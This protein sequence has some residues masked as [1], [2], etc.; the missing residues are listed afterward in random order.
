MD[1][2]ITV[3]QKKY[4]L[5]LSEIYPSVQS[6]CTEIISI[7]ANLNLPKG[8]EHFMSDLH[9]E[10]E[11]FFH[12]LNNC[13]G[14]IKEKV[15]ACFKGRLS[16][17]EC[18]N[19]CTLIYY[20]RERLEMLLKAGAVNACWY[21][22]TLYS[23]IELTSRISSKYTRSKVRSAVPAEYSFIIDELLH[24]QPDEDD[25]QYIYHQR[26]IETVFE[27][28]IGADFIADMA[29]LIKRLA[30][31]RLHIVGDI[32]DRGA[33][34][35]S[36]MDMLSSHHCVDI[37][38][39]NHDILWMGAACGSDVCICGVIR[40]C[41]TYNNTEV[42]E[43]GYGIPLR[44]L[45]L[46]SE[47]LYPELTPLEAA[48]KVIT[49]MMF[50]LEGQLISRHSEYKMDDKMLLHKIDFISRTIE[51]GDK[52]YDVSGDFPTI[53]EYAPYALTIEEER[54]L[55]ELRKAFSES[56][57]L[58][59]HMKFL[60]DNG[61]LYRCHNGNLL[62]HGCI[63][64]NEN[65]SF[66]SM[67]FGGKNYSG[68]EYFD[69]ADKCVRKAY[70]END[71]NLKDFMWFLWSAENS[72]LSGR[73][74]KTFERAYLADE[75]LWA[76]PVN[77]YFKLCNDESICCLILSEFGLDPDT[78]HIINGHTPVRVSDGESPVRGNG[79]LIVIDGGFC[80]LYQKTTGI[81]GYTLISNSHGMRIVSHQPFPGIDKVLEDNGD[82]HSNSAIFDV[83]KERF[84]AAHSDDG[85]R[86]RERLTDLLLLL[87]AYRSGII[88][89]TEI[90]KR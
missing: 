64:L 15:F 70:Y 16:E 83:N 47:K 82:I 46:F 41:I 81:A 88:K 52:I 59:R 75:S 32:Y 28:G 58:H 67:N 3:G 33:R 44:S 5:A 79:R 8:T 43:N 54:L 9:G 27:L 20:P 42:L 30:V 4:L 49:L 76:E 13:S 73:L 80:K 1:E 6:V 61:S 85:K 72:P 48:Q 66:V 74:T 35:D 18:L 23:L 90:I 84:M 77:P 24:A 7:Q 50:K 45:A 60:F 57:K 55:A 51:I 38:W 40:N 65:G 25:N 21:K 63:P 87:K 36:I 2:I 56:E 19:L 17:S 12:I 39:G 53:I 37:E 62:F 22:R 69:Y 10:Y 34:P 11:A 86:L 26:I 31:D 71:S 78:A 29:E 68:R 89:A 14:V